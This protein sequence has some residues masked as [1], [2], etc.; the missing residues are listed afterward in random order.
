MHFLRGLYALRPEQEWHLYGLRI[1]P[2]G[3]QTGG[4]AMLDIIYIGL[5]LAGFALFT[6]AVR[7]LERM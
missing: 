7:G 2:R 1:Q 4:S 3:N 5:G 6:L